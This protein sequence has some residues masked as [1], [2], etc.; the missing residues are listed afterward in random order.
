MRRLRLLCVAALTLAALVPPAVSAAIAPGCTAA[1][2]TFVGGTIRG[3][4]DGRAVNTHIGVVIADA[5]HRRLNPDGTLD[6][7]GGYSWVDMLN[8]T[9]P[10]SGTTDP[11][12]V[13]AWG[14]CV[15][16]LATSFAA[17]AY[18]KRPGGDTDKSRYGA[19]AYYRGTFTVGQRL[20]VGLRLPQT[21][22]CCGA[23]TGGVAGYI[24]YAGRPVPAASVSRVRAF[25]LS[26]GSAC[27]IEGFSAAADALGTNTR[28]YYR[29]D[30]LAA[31]QCWAPSQGYSLQ[32]TCHLV[33]GKVDS[34]VAVRISIVRGQRPRRDVYFQ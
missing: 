28:T 31:G 16:G 14:R 15:S 20:A 11:S 23:N 30:Y 25:P 17:E 29:V 2:P 21:W 18:P 32:L 4:P 22:Q 13:S 3:Y 27:G 6:T 1:R 33:C 8:P 34:N 26:S 24:W 5:A 9:A 12:A 10:A 19:T 7:D